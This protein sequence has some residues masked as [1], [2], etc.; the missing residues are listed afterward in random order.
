MTVPVPWPVAVAGALLAAGVGRAAAGRFAPPVLVLDAG[1]GGRDPGAVADG[2]HEA[3]IVLRA[4]LAV[5]TAWPA[6]VLLTR[7]TDDELTLEQR[8]GVS[9]QGDLLLS[10]HTNAHATA[11]AHG[12]EALANEAGMPFARAIESRWRALVQ[13][14]V[15]L[16]RWRRVIPAVDWVDSRTGRPGLWILRVPAPAVLL[17]LGFISNPGDRAWLVDSDAVRRVVEDVLRVMFDMYRSP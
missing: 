3:D 8:V 13:A 15:Q 16:P 14:G 17:E 10:L 1:H 9:R 6:G 5:R 2:V 12:A 7:E 11:Q 4:A